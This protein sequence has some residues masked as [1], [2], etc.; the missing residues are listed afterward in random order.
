M[1]KLNDS[2][3]WIWSPLGALDPSGTFA[4]HR[5]V[6]TEGGPFSTLGGYRR[7]HLEASHVLDDAQHRQVH[8][9]AEGELLSHVDDGDVLRCCDYQCSICTTRNPSFIV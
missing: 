5:G 7:K 4:G 3:Y 1:D 6:D 2:F 8:L 9:S